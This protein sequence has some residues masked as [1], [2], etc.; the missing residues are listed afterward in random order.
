MSG[1]KSMTIG[2]LDGILADLEKRR[3]AAV[4]ENKPADDVSTLEVDRARVYNE[5]RRRGL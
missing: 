1:L 3:R 4:R 5:L 2:E